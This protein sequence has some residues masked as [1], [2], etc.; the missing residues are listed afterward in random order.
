MASK[1]TPKQI[2]YVKMLLKQAG[3]DTRFLGSWAKAYGLG[4][5]ERS[6]SVEG[7]SYDTASKLI[8]GLKQK[9]GL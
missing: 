2:N 9:L 5:R 4:M 3:H 7:I 8:D 1:A 6:G